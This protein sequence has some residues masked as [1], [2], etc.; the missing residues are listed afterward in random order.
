MIQAVMQAFKYLRSDALN[1]HLPR[2]ISL[3]VEVLNQQDARCNVYAVLLYLS[4]VAR[5]M[6]VEELRV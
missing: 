4:Q 6:S 1:V 2:I 5:R 3:L